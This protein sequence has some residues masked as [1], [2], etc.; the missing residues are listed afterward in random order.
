MNDPDI[1]SDDV[2]N[3]KKEKL[4]SILENRPITTSDNE[5]HRLLIDKQI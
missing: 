5:K 3:K 1:E 2:A 4:V